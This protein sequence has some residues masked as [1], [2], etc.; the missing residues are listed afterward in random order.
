MNGNLNDFEWESVYGS[1]STEQYNGLKI[2][3]YRILKAHIYRMLFAEY[4]FGY[5]SFLRGSL[6]HDYYPGVIDS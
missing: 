3:G 2:R 4:C 5:F 6:Y 1:I